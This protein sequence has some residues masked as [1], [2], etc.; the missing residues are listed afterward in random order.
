MADWQEA[1]DLRLLAMAVTAKKD[2]VAHVDP[3]ET[4]FFWELDT[5]P[6]NRGFLTLAEC[7]SFK[8]HPIGFF[9]PARFAVVFYEQN[10]GWMNERQRAVLMWHEL[11]HIPERGDKLRPHTVQDFHVILREAGLDWND[12]D[13]EVPNILE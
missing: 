3:S 13:G 2:D 9:T 11:K 6:K 7:H 8:R 1:P 12:P 4:L 5:K 10:M